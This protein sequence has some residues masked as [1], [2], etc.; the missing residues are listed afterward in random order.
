MQKANDE[1]LLKSY[2]KQGYNVYRNLMM[3]LGEIC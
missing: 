2:P 1:S 3:E